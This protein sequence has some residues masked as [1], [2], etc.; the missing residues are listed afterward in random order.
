MPKK[1]C[2]LMYSF[3][4]LT[5]IE[6]T[7]TYYINFTLLLMVG[8]GKFLHL[9]PDFKHRFVRHASSLSDLESPTISLST[10]LDFLE[11]NGIK[12]FS[13]WVNRK[14][15][16]KIAHCD[17]LVDDEGIFYILDPKRKRKNL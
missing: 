2:Q 16:N 17:F 3:I 4:Y 5:W 6:T 10:K 12:F 8:P 14:L 7:A 11:S 13:K 1:F 15:R 9:E